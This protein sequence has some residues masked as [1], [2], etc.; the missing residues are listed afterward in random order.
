M[1]HFQKQPFKQLLWKNFTNKFYPQSGQF[2]YFGQI[3]FYFQ[4]QPFADNLQ[5]KCL[6]N[7]A[8][9]TG[10]YLCWSLFLITLHA[11]RLATLLI[12]DSNTDIFC[13]YCKIFEINF[14]YRTPLVTVS[15]L[16][17]ITALNFKRILENLRTMGDFNFTNFLVIEWWDAPRKAPVIPAFAKLFQTTSFRKS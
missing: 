8:I 12:W 2:A 10:I 15:V 7:F 11:F 14:S 3:H 4:K 5:S 1:L 16:W 13:E 17:T 9:F 6:E